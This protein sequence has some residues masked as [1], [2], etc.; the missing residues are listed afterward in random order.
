VGLTVYRLSEILDG[1]LADVVSEI[2]SHFQAR[3]LAS[4]APSSRI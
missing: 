3:L 4:E 1:D 2:A